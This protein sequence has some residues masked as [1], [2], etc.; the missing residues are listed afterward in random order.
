MVSVEKTSF[1]EVTSQLDPGGNFYLYLG[2]AQ[3]LDNLSDKLGAWRQIIAALPDLKP[4]DAANVNKA[5]DIATRLIKDS[6]IEDVSGVGM[7]SV[8]IEKGMYRNKMLLH[9]YS[10][11]G[12]G[13]LWQLAGGEPHPLTGLDFL[14]TD[15]A[16]AFF[17]D[18]DLPLL[19]NVAKKE[20][21]KADL[22]QAQQWLNNLPVQFNRA[23]QVKWNDFLDSLGG[24]FGL[25]V[26]LDPDN[27]L[28]LPLPGAAHADSPARIAAR[29]QSERRHHFQPH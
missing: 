20:I 6:G 16:M 15:T 4:E 19:W 18:A 2:T 25:V 5:F 26:T 22:P 13:F 21:S 7:S 8:E 3:W 11:K 24:E 12:D 17:S 14:P 23:T 1:S 27:D 29:D 28:S 10:G 9:H